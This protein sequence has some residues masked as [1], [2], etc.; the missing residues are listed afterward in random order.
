MISIN[1]SREDRMDKKN[2]HDKNKHLKI[3]KN[4]DAELG[5]FEIGQKDFSYSAHK[6]KDDFLIHEK[7]NW[8]HPGVSGKME[9]E[10]SWINK[11]EYYEQVDFVGLGPKG[12]K[13]SDDRIYE[14]VCESLMK[15]RSVDASNIGVK[16]EEGIVILNGKVPTRK[17]KKMAESVIDSLPGVQDVRNELIIIKDD[18]IKGP[19]SAIR[20]D[21][22]LS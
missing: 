7:G 6:R 17:M 2:G 19:D 11:D 3:V 8:T 18:P 20:N 5:S 15:S 16:V 14:E 21:L 22:G 4:Y 12:Y 9:N 13:R 1:S 10:S